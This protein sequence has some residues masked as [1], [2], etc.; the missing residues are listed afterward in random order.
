MTVIACTSTYKVHYIACASTNWLGL[1]L[2]GSTA[3]SLVPLTPSHCLQ[4]WQSKE[5]DHPSDT[6]GRSRLQKIAWSCSACLWTDNPWC[7]PFPVTWSPAVWWKL[8]TQGL[9]WWSILQQWSGWYWRVPCTLVCADSWLHPRLLAQ[10]LSGKEKQGCCILSLWTFMFMYQLTVAL[11]LCMNG[12]YGQIAA[13]EWIKESKSC[14]NKT[15]NAD[16][17]LIYLLTIRI[18]TF[19]GLIWWWRTNIIS[20]SSDRIRAPPAKR[21]L[22]LHLRSI[23]KRPFS[24]RL[25]CFSRSGCRSALGCTSK[26]SWCLVLLSCRISFMNGMPRLLRSVEFDTYH[27]PEV[28]RTFERPSRILENNI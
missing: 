9:W 11:S 23:G 1:H 15:V 20:P 18:N 12:M 6:T 27:K 16:F 24:L 28:K 10:E 2:C 21:S 17:F 26:W 13:A 14:V 5:S 22:L 19:Y 4:I 8:L 7:L 3:D 25:F